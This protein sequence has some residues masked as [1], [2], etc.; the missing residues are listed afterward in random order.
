MHCV[1]M[2]MNLMLRSKCLFRCSQGKTERGD[3]VGLG[4]ARSCWTKVG[5]YVLGEEH[6][7]GD[8][9]IKEG[10]VLGNS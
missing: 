9:V 6:E 10:D 7:V 4:S 1:I 2:L 8:K 3:A 5:L